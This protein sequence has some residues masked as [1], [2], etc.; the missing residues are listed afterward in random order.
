MRISVSN[1]RNGL[2]TTNRGSWTKFYKAICFILRCKKGKKNVKTITPFSWKIV[3][4]KTIS[5]VEIV[6]GN[7]MEMLEGGT[8]A[9][10]FCGLRTHKVGS[11]R[12]N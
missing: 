9:E 10:N 2:K 7:A 4:D 3:I 6:E 12:H 8:L 1:L 5:L 11:F